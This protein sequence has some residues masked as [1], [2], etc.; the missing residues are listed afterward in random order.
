MPWGMLFPSTASQLPVAIPKDFECFISM[1]LMIH[2]V[3]LILDGRSYEESEIREWLTK[4]RSSPFNRKEMA[5]GQTIDSVLVPN[6]ALAGSI[7]EFL[8]LH[9]EL[10]P[11]ASV[12][13]SI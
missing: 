3:S 12:Q 6:L 5:Q 13:A 2:P 1:Q 10:T 11:G 7:E 4:H 9:P 8:K